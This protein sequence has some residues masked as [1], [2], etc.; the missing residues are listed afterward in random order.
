MRKYVSLKKYQESRPE[1][2]TSN[3]AD[4]IFFIMDVDYFKQI[5]DTHGHMAGDEVLIQMKNII[6][7]VFRESDY[8]VRW[9]GEEFLIVARAC[10]RE[11]APV[12]A[13]RLRK[14]MEE[15]S[16]DIGD[17]VTIKRTCSIG[18]AC[19]PFLT[20][21]TEQITWLNV[22]AIADHCLIAAKK[23]QRNAWIG[24]YNPEKTNSQIS[25]QVIVGNTAELIACNEVGIES[26]IK[27]IDSII[28]D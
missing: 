10:D 9:G 17:G 19:F 21:Q 23:T 4:L 22:I 3:E 11:A 2:A 12:L 25:F 14:T 8:M 5:N 7:K 6:Q 27:E 24:L 26:S 18:F 13:E 15:Y 28:W 16:F 1:R 20:E